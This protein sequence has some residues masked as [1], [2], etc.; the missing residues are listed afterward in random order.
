MFE[1]MEG[2]AGHI[3]AKDRQCIDNRREH[4][5]KLRGLMRES[6]HWGEFPEV[7]RRAMP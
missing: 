1:Q 7:F 3:L 2:R 6:L 5:C 4:A